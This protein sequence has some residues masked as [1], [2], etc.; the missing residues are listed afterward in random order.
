MC[1]DT[2]HEFG[3]NGYA[4]VKASPLLKLWKRKNIRKLSRNYWF[5]I[6]I[7]KI[8]YRGFSRN[9][10]CWGFWLIY[11]ENV[12]CSFLKETMPI[13][14]RN[15]QIYLENRMKPPFF[16]FFIFNLRSSLLAGYVP[17]PRKILAMPLHLLLS[18]Q[19]GEHSKLKCWI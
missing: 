14:E 19:I 4:K 9:T 17:L 18:A 3:Q 10:N 1:R 8:F 16:S 15:I 2:P 6:K 13:F 11:I 7:F 12:K 5:S